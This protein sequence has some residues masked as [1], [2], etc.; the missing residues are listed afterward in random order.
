MIDNEHTEFDEPGD[1]APRKSRWQENHG[2][3]LMAFVG[4]I[5]LVGSGV[6][7]YRQNRFVPPR[8]PQSNMI[9]P[10][11]EESS[12]SDSDLSNQ[13]VALIRV[14]GAANDFGTIKIAIYENEETFNNPDLAFATNSLPLNDGEAIWA[15][16]VNR[17]PEMMSIAVYHDENQ[18]E[19]LTLNRFGI[20]SERYGFSGNA[21]GLAGPPAFKQTLIDRPVN[22]QT[23]ELFIR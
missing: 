16:P 12:E 2:S 4:L 6:L 5:M 18:D 17:L 14:T 23:L 22:G 15:V 9:A 7:I 11:A 8:F 21:R 10:P 3:L 1:Y 20:P 13:E 19:Q